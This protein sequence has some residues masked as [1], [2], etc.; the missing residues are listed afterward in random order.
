MLQLK[1]HITRQLSIISSFAIVI[2]YSGHEVRLEVFF[3]ARSPK[4]S[5]GEPAQNMDEWS[6]KNV[7]EAKVL[8]P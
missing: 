4:L 5:S 8:K 6:L 7:K 1:F 2:N 3:P